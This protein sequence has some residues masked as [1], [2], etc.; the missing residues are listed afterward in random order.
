MCSYAYC[1]YLWSCKCISKRYLH[2]LLYYMKSLQYSMH[3]R[4]SKC[5]AVM[6][7]NIRP[8]LSC[9]TGD[10]SEIDVPFS[11]KTNIQRA[12]QYL[13]HYFYQ[14]YQLINNANGRLTNISPMFLKHTYW[15][16]LLMDS[17]INFYKLL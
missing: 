10:R 6:H 4:V 12:L 7:G 13:Q 15:C 2:L 1:M 8:H 16:C 11:Y 3:S 5:T 17:V 9:T 14:H